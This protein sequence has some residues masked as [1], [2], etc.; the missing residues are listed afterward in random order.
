[1]HS[2]AGKFSLSGL[3]GSIDSG[4][5]AGALGGFLGGA[6]GKVIGMAGRAVAGGLLSDGA[7][8]AARQETASAA[9]GG[10]TTTAARD[11]TSSIAAKDGSIDLYHGTSSGGA[12]NI[13]SNGIDVS[14]G[15]ANRDFGQGFYTTRLPA[16]AARWASDNFGDSSTVLH[17]RVPS[18]MFDGLSGKVF[19]DA[20]GEYL[21]MVR[22][23]RSGGMHS[24]DY[25]EGPVLRNPRDFLA[26]KEPITFGN[27][28]S[29]NS[30]T[31]V[32]L[33][34]GYLLP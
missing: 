8:A 24:F 17:Y 4:A 27:Q 18:S 5:V 23:M 26:G 29:F 22:S 2:L 15:R 25:V 6:G 30:E 33:L 10:L 21:D 34:N 3:A 32:N 31:S 19:P 1:V 16:Q 11:A 14:A 13:R 12:A 20:N 7:A 28:I 9:A